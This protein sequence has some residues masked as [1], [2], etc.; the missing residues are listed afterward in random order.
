MAVAYEG[1][2]SVIQTTTMNSSQSITVPAGATFAL[3]CIGGYDWVTT[4]STVTLAGVS[5]TSVLLV[6]GGAD[7]MSHVWRVSG[8]S[9]GSQTLAWN[10]NGTAFD[11][12]Q[13]V[14]LFFSGQ[15]ATPIAD[16]DSSLATSISL[17]LTGAS[18]DMGVLFISDYA[19]DCSAAG[20]G[21]TVVVDSGPYRNNEID[22]SYEAATG[23]TTTMT[24]SGGGDHSAIAILIAAAAA[25]GTTHSGGASLGAAGWMLAQTSRIAIGG[26]GLGAAGWMLAAGQLLKQGAL[27][28]GAAG[29][30]G[31]FG[32]RVALGSAQLGG[33]GWL[34]GEGY[35]IL[36]GGTGQGGAGWLNAETLKVLIGAAGMEAIGRMLAEADAT[37]TG[38]THTGQASLDG[39]GY[40]LAAAERVAQAESGQ[41]GAGWL[42]AFGERVAL[43]AAELAGTGYISAAGQRVAL[44][45][46][47]LPGAGWVNISATLIISASATMGAAGYLSARVSV[48]ATQISAGN[49]TPYSPNTRDAYQ[50]ELRTGKAP[51][52]RRV[53]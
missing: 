30:I 28:V 1:V 37:G 51:R 10:L 35:R 31:A 41:G 4:S 3:V 34:S 9:T 50:P 42:S 17:A 26:A 44:G 7:E 16:S 6:G 14:T 11:G 5:A 43:A 19:N 36:E 27:S 2:S 22:A 49:R 23:T 39:H 21:Q 20:T 8:F 38:T 40:I 46:I 32:E 24:G 29:F 45:A 48:Q 18:G 53:Y 12:I 52:A 15:H 13:I 47:E 33:A 25:G